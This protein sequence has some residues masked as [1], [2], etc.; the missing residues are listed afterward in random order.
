MQYNET[1]DVTRVQKG[2]TR[3]KA[4]RL[5]AVLMI[6]AMSATLFAGCQT[7]A[8]QGSSDNG[9][10]ETKDGKRVLTFSTNSW[11]APQ[12]VPGLQEL[13]DQWEEENNAELEIT[14]TTDDYL[15]KLLQDINAGNEADIVMVDGSNLAE[16]NATG[17]MVSLDKWYTDEMRSEHFTYAA[18][19]S[20]IDGETKAIWFHGGLWNLYYREDLLKEAGFDGPPKDWDELIE[21]GKALTVDEDGDGTI[22]RYGLGLPAF[23]DAVTVCTLLPWFW[24]HGEDVNLTDGKDKVI[25]GEGENFDAMLDTAEFLQTLMDEE[26]VAADIASV[27]FNDVQANF[28]GGQTAMAI[29]GNWHYPLM[30]ESGGDEFMENVGVADIPAVPGQE[31]TNTAG[32]WTLAMFTDDP[33]QQ[34]LAWSFMDF[35]RGVE[36]QTL[37]TRMGQM[38]SLKAVYEQDEFKNDPVWQVYVKGLETARTRDAVPFYSAVDEGFRQIVQSATT[39]EEDLSGVIKY[40]AEKAQESADEILNQ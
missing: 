10:G 17:A 31:P 19:G 28:V 32:G 11:A 34:E 30:Q 3:M 35:Y 6:A 39:G 13:F 23:P 27:D 2:G 21:M 33:E 20:V 1:K 22:D 14:T 4:K 9:G 24:G 26:I 5:T 12:N 36:V 18:E 7:K 38:S 37:F 16:I 25:F 8:P 40:E 29:L 15:P